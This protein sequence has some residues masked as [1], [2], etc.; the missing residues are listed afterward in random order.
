[1]RTHFV[2]I[3]LAGSLGACAS[4][5]RDEQFQ[6]SVTANP[7]RELW[8]LVGSEQ[9]VP[10]SRKG[11]QRLY[12][13]WSAEATAACAGSYV[14]TPAIQVTSFAPPGQP[15][16]DPFAPSVHLRFTAALGS[17]QC[18]SLVASAFSDSP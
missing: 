1:M 14:G 15:F 9:G 10:S 5:P 6:S 8:I 2:L 7:E 17:A 16:E 18:T 12:E 13:A 4:L 3:V 11:A